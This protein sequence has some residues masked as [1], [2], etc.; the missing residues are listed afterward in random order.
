MTLSYLD[1]VNIRT[2]DLERLA[3]FYRDSLGLEEGD[4][5]GFSFGGAWL[6]CGDKAA[7]HLTEVADQPRTGEPRIEHFAF[8]AAGLAAFLERLRRQDVA[9]SVRLVPGIGNKQVH[10][11]DPDG[12]HIEIQ[13]GAEE[14]ADLTPFDGTQDRPDSKA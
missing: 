14:E 1:H 6:Y 3:R 13:F 8:R 10:I 12:N 2:A 11:F 7:V 5:P 4:R 9:Y